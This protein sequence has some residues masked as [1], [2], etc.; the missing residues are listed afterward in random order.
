MAHAA[1]S[2]LQRDSG[3]GSY[4]MMLLSIRHYHEAQH[5][6]LPECAR[7]LNQAY[8]KTIAASQDVMALTMAWQE[9]PETERYESRVAQATEHLDQQ[10]QELAERTEETNLIG[11]DNE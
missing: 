6:E 7:S 4:Y 11:Q 5:E 8:I 1:D 2:R 3:F 9:N 10:W